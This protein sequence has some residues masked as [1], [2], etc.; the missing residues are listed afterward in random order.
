MALAV[1]GAGNLYAGGDFNTAGGIPANNVA[2]WDGNVWSALGNGT[3]G[4]IAA[5]AWDG[6]GNLYAGGL[7]TLP[8][9]DG[10]TWSEFGGMAIW[11]VSALAASP[12]KC[13]WAAISLGLAA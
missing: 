8:R 2:R 1:D 7:W 3:D 9:W 13:S 4:R 10:S 5:L 12:G 11:E 6:A